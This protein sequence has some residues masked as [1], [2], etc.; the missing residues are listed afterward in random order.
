MLGTGPTFWDCETARG[1]GGK[2]MPP[3]CGAGGM[4][5]GASFFLR[6]SAAFTT[7]GTGAFA[8]PL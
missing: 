1:G 2:F 3:I 8:R 4:L 7:C 5:C 6:A